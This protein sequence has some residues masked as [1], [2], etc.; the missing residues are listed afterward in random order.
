MGHVDTPCDTT[1]GAYEAPPDPK[2]DHATA[3]RTTSTS[4][5]ATGHL[6]VAEDETDTRID[7][8]P[9]EYGDRFELLQPIPVE[10]EEVAPGAVIAQF[11]E[12]DLAITGDDRQDAQDSLASWILDVFDDLIEAEPRMLGATPAMQIRVLR[13]YLR[14]RQ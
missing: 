1:L 12:A 14:H 10:F 3:S 5:K 9:E 6:E 7:T 2:A 4:G 8:I 13:Q 11:V